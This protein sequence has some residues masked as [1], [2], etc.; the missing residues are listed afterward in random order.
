MKRLEKRLTCGTSWKIA[1]SLPSGG[2]SQGKT[3]EK[4]IANLREAIPG[5]LKGLGRRWA[6]GPRRTI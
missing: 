5:Y 1:K 6:S 4:A 2:I 3:K